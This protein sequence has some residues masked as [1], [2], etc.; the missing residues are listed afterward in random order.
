MYIPNQINV[1]GSQYKFAHQFDGEKSYDWKIFLTRTRMKAVDQPSQRC[2][3][4]GDYDT[5]ACIARYIEK[6]LGCNPRIHGSGTSIAQLRL[7]NSTTQLKRLANISMDLM[8]TDANGIYNVTGCLA[9]CEKN[10]YQITMAETPKA[11]GGSRF[12]SDLR[13]RVTIQNGMF[14]EREQYL[15]YDTD[16]FV[17]DIGGFLGLLLGWSMYGVYQDCAGIVGRMRD[18]I[19]QN[20]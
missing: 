14:E 1:Y 4:I 18:K 11:N 12:G 7:C 3:D 15:I 10:K 6:E 9:S 20:I 19:M 8:E 16:S 5:S 2:T 17:A 13:I